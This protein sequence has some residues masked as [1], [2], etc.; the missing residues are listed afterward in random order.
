MFGDFGTARD[1]A[2][3]LRSTRQER[4]SWKAAVQDLRRELTMSAE[5][6]RLRLSALEKEF[7]DERAVRKKEI[8]R[9][10]ERSLLL[11]L[12]AGGMGYAAGR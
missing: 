7:A 3:A 12:I 10:R 1:T 9:E 2:E 5:E 8:R 6:N 11:I 4:D